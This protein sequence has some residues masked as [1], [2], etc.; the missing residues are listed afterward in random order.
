MTIVLMG[1]LSS[2]K[3]QDKIVFNDGKVVESKVLEITPEVIK[4][5]KYTMPDGPIYTV[6]RADINSIVF[7][8]GKIELIMPT[9]SSLD[10]K[11]ERH[12]KRADWPQY[13]ASWGLDLLSP[14][15]KELETWF[16]IRNKKDMIGHTISL[17]GYWDRDGYLGYV[18]ETCL[19]CYSAFGG[20]GIAVAYAPKFYFIDH[21]IVK[22]FAG[23]E[24]ALG[25]ITDE[26]SI[27]GYFHGLTR[28]GVTITPKP[29]FNLTLDIAGGGYVSFD[30]VD[31][32]G[33]GLISFGLSLGVNFGK[34][35][36]KNE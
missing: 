1:A 30:K 20:G 10:G 3:A 7:E 22:P 12:E 23:P 6:Y 2:L 26:Y 19:D 5:T 17:V 29:R 21:P 16:E 14:F 33:G 25:M 32:Y 11:E 34:V 35:G 8:N 36:G 13:R 27:E 24:V 31:G 28:V 4:Y 9:T 18:D 15:F